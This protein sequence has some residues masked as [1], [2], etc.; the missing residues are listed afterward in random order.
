MKARILAAALFGTACAASSSSVSSATPSSGNPAAFTV[1]GPLKFAARP[2]STD[3]TPIDLMSRLYVFADDSMMGRDDGG[4]LGATKATAYI[5]RE[6][7]RL[8][9]AP[10]GDNDTFFQ[11]IG[12]RS[13]SRRCPVQFHRRGPSAG[14]WPRF[15][16]GA[17]R[18][19]AAASRRFSNHLRRSGRFH[20]A[21]LGI[22]SERQD[23][24]AHHAA[25]W[26]WRPRRWSRRSRR[27]ASREAHSDVDVG[28]RDRRRSR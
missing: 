28:Q 16:A 9:L 13:G 19:R 23:R 26:R 15:R 12:Y 7:R 3:I 10:A 18:R 25:W 1:E 5:E 21:D 6:L 4:P 24:H 22:A 14:S 8:G 27:C 2:T 20:A 11:D 17:S